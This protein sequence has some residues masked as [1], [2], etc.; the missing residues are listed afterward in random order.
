MR[1][2]LFVL[3][4]YYIKTGVLG[5]WATQ[6]Q[7]VVSLAYACRWMPEQVRVLPM[8]VACIRP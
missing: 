7:L 3:V 4:K 1:N 6:G 5:S 2:I 8:L